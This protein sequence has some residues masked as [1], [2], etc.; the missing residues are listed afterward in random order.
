MKANFHDIAL[1]LESRMVFVSSLFDIWF[2]KL[3]NIW[4]SILLQAD[5]PIEM[6]CD[7]NQ[8]NSSQVFYGNA[9]V[10]EGYT[11][12]RAQDLQEAKDQLVVETADMLVIRE[13]ACLLKTSW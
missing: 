5:I 8:S 12:L 2:N 4:L 7:L 11:G 9:A 13:Y 6:N 1:F 10:E 3:F